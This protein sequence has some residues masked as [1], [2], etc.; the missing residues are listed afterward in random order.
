M[1]FG[2]QVHLTAKVGDTKQ[3]GSWLVL[4]VEE[5][6]DPDS[7]L[8]RISP[9]SGQDSLV[10]MTRWEWMDPTVRWDANGALGGES[11]TDGRA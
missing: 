5:V 10:R 2:G 1:G 3:I 4:S 7:L 9:R 8:V 6:G 11:R